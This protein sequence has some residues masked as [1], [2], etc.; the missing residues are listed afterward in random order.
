VLEYAKRTNQV[1]GT[2]NHDMISSVPRRKSVIWIDPRGRQWRSAPASSP[3]P[4]APGPRCRDSDSGVVTT[5]W[6]GLT[7]CPMATSA[8]AR[9]PVDFDVQLS[10]QIGSPGT[11]AKPARRGSSTGTGLCRRGAFDLPRADAPVRRGRRRH[12]L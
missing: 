11:R 4:P 2:S 10:G 8:S 1:V 5:P 7:W 3:W 12:R 9:W 6:W